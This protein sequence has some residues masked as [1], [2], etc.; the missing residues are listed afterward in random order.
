MPSLTSNPP[1]AVVTLMTFAEMGRH[2]GYLALP[3]H[4]CLS[5][6]SKAD[7]HIAPIDHSCCSFN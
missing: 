3:L 5:Y 6:W 2:P 4:R 1:S 7:T